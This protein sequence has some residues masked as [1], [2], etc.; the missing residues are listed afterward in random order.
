MFIRE[1]CPIHRQQNLRN[2]RN[3]DEICLPKAQGYLE[4]WLN[5]QGRVQELDG[6]FP[7]QT[8][9]FCE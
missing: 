9:K 4:E 2:L 5:G 8:L 1:V 3:S 6:A 7:W